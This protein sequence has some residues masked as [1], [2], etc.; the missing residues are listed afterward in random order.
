M[1]EVGLSILPD[2]PIDDAMIRL[3]SSSRPV[4][5]QGPPYV[6]AADGQHLQAIF[7]LDN[8]LTFQ[9]F[10]LFSITCFDLLLQK[11][12]MFYNFL[13]F[14]TTFYFC[15]QRSI[16]FHYVPLLSKS[17]QFFPSLSTSFSVFPNH[18]FVLLMFSHYFF[19]LMFSIAFCYFWLLSTSF[20][21]YL[22]LDTSFWA[23]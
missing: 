15:Q 21:F 22:P 6:G 10:P 16:A 11:D 8:L 5:V 23:F 18:V 20:C 2:L 17:C 3:E 19:F 12:I 7:R 14:S 13:L 1:A 4:E 9:Y